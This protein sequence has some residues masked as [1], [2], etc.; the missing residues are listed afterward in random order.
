[1]RIPKDELARNIGHVVM[2]WSQ[3]EMSVAVLLQIVLH[4]PQADARRMIGGQ[5]FSDSLK[6]LRKRLEADYPDLA[7]PFK[8]WCDLA[9]KLSKERHMAA[10]QVW[11]YDPHS[12][13]WSPTDLTSSRSKEGVVIDAISAERLPDLYADIQTAT[14]TLAQLRIDV[15][16]VN[17]SWK[18]IFHLHPD[19][20]QV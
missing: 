13:R 4:V 20:P 1:M 19:T 11:A 9:L 15:Q 10:H 12:D 7:D 17:S 14:S 3:V 5:R 18:P 8:G 2:A 6:E 16:K